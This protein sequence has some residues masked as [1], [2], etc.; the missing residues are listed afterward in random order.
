MRSRPRSG[1]YL[2]SIM[3][4][5]RDSG[6]RRWC[7]TLNNYTPE[8]EATARNL[9][10]EADKY[11]FAI[12]GKE[13]GESGTPHLQGFLHFKQKQRLTALKKLFPR[14]HFE[15]ARGSDQ[16]NADYC[17]K[18][19]E[20]LTMIGTPS[21]N[22]PSDLAGAVAAVK[23]GS[24]MS[25]IAREFSEVFVKYG[26][27]LRDLRLLIG[28]PPRDFKTEVIVLIG[29]PGCGKSKL[30]N[31][32]EGSKFYKMK[33]DWWDGYDNQDIVIIDD[34]YGWLP[35]CECLRLCDRYP[36]RVPVKG[37]Y[38]E[39]TSKKIVFTSNRHVD[40]WWKGEIEKSAFYRRINVYKFYETGEF[41][42]MPGH[43]LPHPIN[44]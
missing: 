38:V 2:R 14:A 7:F 9:T 36:H 23:R 20:I 1:R 6:A 3:A 30:A 37:A 16:Q 42:D 24:Q 29:P 19:G 44:Y 10:L 4:A 27:G 41:R 8:E 12:I 34:F 40:G 39:F 22:K 25:E 35:Y 13:V 5:R 15:K 31:E 33:G 17:G 21:D 18:D 11:A 32:M 28:C 43:M 26:R